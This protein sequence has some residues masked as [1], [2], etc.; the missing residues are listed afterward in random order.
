[1]VRNRRWVWAAAAFLACTAVLG[2]R[3]AVQRHRL[4]VELATPRDLHRVAYVGSRACRDCH[5]DHVATW[6][7]TFHRTMTAEATAAFVKGD[8]A[9]ATLESSGVRT[10]MDRTPDGGYRMTF[11]RPG[12]APRVATVDR[13]VGSHRYQ[14]YLTRIGDTYWRL[15][16]AWSVTDGRW[17]PMTSAFLFPDPDPADGRPSDEAGDGRPSAGVGDREPDGAGEGRPSAGVRGRPSDG[18]GG[19]HV[20]GADGRE[21]DGARDGRPSDGAGGREPDG[22]RDGRPSDGAGGRE[23]D[24]AADRPS[25]GAG[26]REPDGWRPVFGA[27]EFDR[28]VTRWNDNCVFCHNVAPNPG[29][30]PES[31]RF[32]TTVA[33]LGVACEAC[34]GPGGE[35]AAR[36]ADPA[37]RA[38]L[39]G[40]LADPTIVNPSRLSPE[41]AADL[42]GRCHGQRL[43]DDVAPFLAHGDPFVPGDDLALESVPLW[44]DTALHGDP[45]A[46]AARFWEDG[47]AR[48][49]AYEYQGLLQ[50]PCAMRGALT[51]TSC[52]GMHDGD[53]RGQIR[54][55][56]AARPDDLCTGCHQ[57]LAAPAAL[58]AHAHHDPAGEGGRCVSCHMPRIVYGVLDVHRSH[59]IELPDPAR[60]A[61]SGR[62]D[63]CTGCH[64]DRTAAWAQTAAGRWWGTGRYPAGIPIPDGT[65]PQEAV[66]SG[67][68]IA[69]AVA[70]DALGRAP[71]RS[72]DD[73]AA[74]LDLLRQVL[75]ADRYPAV[76]EIAWRAFRRLAG[77]ALTAQL[78]HRVGYDP[79]GSAEA[80][81]LATSRLRSAILGGRT[82]PRMPL[83]VRA[84]GPDLEIGE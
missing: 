61:S 62:P 2:A 33:E 56:F 13:T 30:D 72:A 18:V 45:T 60:N 3:A 79:G 48:L 12:Q 55:R 4:T 70:A 21:P 53:P 8:F 52:H 40:G 67:E 22:A 6:K 23:P 14:Q 7:R 29:R 34:H 43:A 42:C 59:R 20:A 32:A 11:Q 27:G 74:R 44:R 65:A 26:G 80:R 77:E 9:G 41:R 82:L 68:A 15:P 25:D 57:A 49:T 81:R 35:H 16:V 50:S 28:H 71:V 36:N 51:C 38:R 63:A 39:A 75:E 47:T 37:R 10:R 1:M 76:R 19:R 17:F 58:A 83:P 24:G 69:R 54:A 66:L 73:R 46:F 84:T 78:V 31:G 64:V 5:L